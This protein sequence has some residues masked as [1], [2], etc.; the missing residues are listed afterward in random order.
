[1]KFSLVSAFFIGL[2]ALVVADDGP[3]YFFAPGDNAEFYTNGQI[4]FTTNGITNDADETIIAKLFNAA[5]DSLIKQIGSYTGETI[6]R[7]DDK[8]PWSFTWVVDVDPGTYYVRLYEQDADGQIDDDDEWDNEIISY[9]F[10]VVSP[11]SKRKRSLRHSQRAQAL[12][13]ANL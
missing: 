8:D 11:P 5:D 7:P 1:M 2:A 6:V 10:R 12:R 9:D 4:D 13:K 3:H